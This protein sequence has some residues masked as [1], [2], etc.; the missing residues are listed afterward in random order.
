M[1]IAGHKGFAHVDQ[2]DHVPSDA[3]SAVNVDIFELRRGSP[4]LVVEA[5][6]IFQWVLR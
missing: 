2:F 5:P 3:D 1:S 6:L 4:L